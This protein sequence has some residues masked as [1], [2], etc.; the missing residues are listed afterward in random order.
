LKKVAVTPFARR[1]GKIS[2][3]LAP[4]PDDAHRQAKVTLVRYA[5][6]SPVRFLSPALW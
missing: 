2:A 4:G 5:A 3:V 6:L 1:T